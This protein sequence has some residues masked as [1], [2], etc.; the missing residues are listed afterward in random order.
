[1]MNGFVRTGNGG[2]KR[3]IVIERDFLARWVREMKQRQDSGNLDYYTGYMSAMSTVEGMLAI[4]KAYDLDRIADMPHPGLFTPEEVCMKMVEHGQG[5]LERFA[6]GEKIVYS[7][8]EV[9][10]LLKCELPKGKEV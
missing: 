7:P 1:M 3:V 4:A 6:W 5:N 2:M 8:S 9:M 10:R